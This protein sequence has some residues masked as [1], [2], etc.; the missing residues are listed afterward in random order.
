[1]SRQ[2]GSRPSLAPP[3]PFRTLLGE[4]V[5]KDYAEY[6]EGHGKVRLWHLGNRIAVFESTGGLTG[7]HAK[8]II[9]WHGRF[10]EKSPRPW[11]TFGNWM[12]LL[13]YTPDT[14]KLLTDWQVKTAYD[15]LYVAHDSRLLAMGIGVANA[16]LRNVV[17]VVPTEEQLDDIL[18]TIR[19]RHGL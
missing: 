18:V 13:S 2:D 7:E 12:G 8:F 3:R 4:N 11:Y 19:K 1:M 10:I 6:V 15:E 14:R 16:V 5:G 17:V 9:D